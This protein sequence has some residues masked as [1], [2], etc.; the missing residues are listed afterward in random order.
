MLP[1]NGEA[2][3]E[4]R[5]HPERDNGVTFINPNLCS[6]NEIDFGSGFG[7]FKELRK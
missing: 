3:E 1:L 4:G 2:G 7:R 6:N 5:R